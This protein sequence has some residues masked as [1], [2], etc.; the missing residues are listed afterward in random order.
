MKKTII[1]YFILT[2]FL[3]LFC[4]TSKEYILN[5]KGKD[6]DTKAIF[7]EENIE[8]IELVNPPED[9]NDLYWQYA[10]YEFYQVDLKESLKENEETVAYLLVPGT[11]IK[12]VVV[13]GENNSFYLN[14]S[15][16]KSYNK[17]GWIFSDYRNDLNNLKKNSIIYAHGRKDKTMFGTLQNVL[18]ESWFNNKDNHVI[19]LSTLKYNYIFLIFSV[20]KVPQESYYLK[21]TFLNKDSYQE[22]LDNIKN[23]SLYDFETK[24]D[25]NDK[26]L[27]LSTCKEI[28]NRIV[29]HA[30]LIKKGTIVP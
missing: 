13:Q 22:F 15:F 21:N 2:I 16:D 11:N 8:R 14:H 6:I 10:N 7:K 20:Y 12:E 27:T 1:L 24:V 9:E 28:V 17:A 23:R 25:S 5:I 26:I 4:L 18:D 3:A 19:Y 30:K 29:V